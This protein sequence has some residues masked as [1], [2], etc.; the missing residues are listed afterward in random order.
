MKQNKWDT[1]D[2]ESTPFLV[3]EYGPLAGIRV[4]L[5]G[6]VV[7]AP[8]AAT[9]LSDFGAEVI[10]LERPGKGDVARHQV[11]QIEN[12]DKHISGAWAQNARN[13]LSMTM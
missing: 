12:G 11:P 5:S 9:M 13:K 7:A 10:A 8:F 3:P 2:R 1:L 4:L 6:S